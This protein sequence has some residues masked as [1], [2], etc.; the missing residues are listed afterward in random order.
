MT[1]I[2][3]GGKGPGGA[4]IALDAAIYSAEAVK[5]A[6]FVFADRAVIR[7]RPGKKASYVS[8]SA[9]A[10]QP[11]HAIGLHQRADNRNVV[12][13]SLGEGINA[14]WSVS[15]PKN[16]IDVAQVV[17]DDQNRALFGEVFETAHLGVSA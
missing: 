2:N 5:L 13:F 14:N 16:G 6:A 9:A 15:Q 7:I 8:V 11:D 17:D 1:K 3:H 10:L 12:E 4:E